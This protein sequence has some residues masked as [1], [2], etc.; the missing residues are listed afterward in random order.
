MVISGPSPKTLGFC[1][2][3]CFSSGQFQGCRTVGLIR[4][5]AAF[6]TEASLK[7]SPVLIAKMNGVQIPQVFDLFVVVC[8]ILTCR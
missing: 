3:V 5:N 4:G 2:W 1:F 8:E 7:V 6:C